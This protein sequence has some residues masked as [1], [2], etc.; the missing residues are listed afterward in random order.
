VRERI[1][2]RPK[3]RRFNNLFIHS[4][5]RCEF[6]H[7]KW[8]LSLSYTSLSDMSKVCSTLEQV[9]FT[10]ADISGGLE[11]VLVLVC[12]EQSLGSLPRKFVH[13]KSNI[14]YKDADLYPISTITKRNLRTRYVYKAIG[15]LESWF[16]KRFS[17]NSISALFI[18]WGT[19]AYALPCNNRIVWKGLVWEV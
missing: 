13:Q 19:C 12:N 16:M 10:T 9:E 2:R 18:K 11:V 1:I 8:L 4:Q 3:K 7:L 6:L 14:I 17:L 15:C 5:I